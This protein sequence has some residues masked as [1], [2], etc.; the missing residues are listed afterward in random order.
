MLQQLER[1]LRS[2]YVKKK[3][4]KKHKAIAFSVYNFQKSV[5]ETT[6]HICSWCCISISK[7]G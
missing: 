6:E 5:T 7:E 4:K 1:F 2:R 3:K